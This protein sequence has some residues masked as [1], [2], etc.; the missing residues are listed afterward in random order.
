MLETKISL[1]TTL[2][3]QL[4]EYTASKA[5]ISLDRIDCYPY[6]TRGLLWALLFSTVS[7]GCAVVLLMVVF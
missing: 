3:K 6:A 7:W 2:L 5:E 4:T 1:N